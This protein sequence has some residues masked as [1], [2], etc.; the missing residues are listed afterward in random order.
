[1]DERR[2]SRTR[3]YVGLLA[4]LVAIIFIAQNAQKVEVD[5]I[6]TETQTPLVFALL[7]AALLGFV[8]GL[9]LPRFRRR[10]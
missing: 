9:V 10:D 4:L 5:F 7:L 6:F 8:V 3:L 2:D 1:V